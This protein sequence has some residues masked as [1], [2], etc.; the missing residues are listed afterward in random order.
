MRQNPLWAE[1]IP[2]WIKSLTNMLSAVAIL[3]ET[4]SEKLELIMKISHL[5][6]HQSYASVVQLKVILI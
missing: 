4:K 1:E 3:S 6:K 5:K 2:R